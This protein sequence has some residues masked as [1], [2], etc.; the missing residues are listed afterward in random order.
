MYQ[1]MLLKSINVD[2]FKGDVGPYFRIE[3][4]NILYGV[5]EPND[6]CRYKII[7]N[8]VEIFDIVE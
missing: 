1:L 6:L 4:R 8:F 3:L 7:I 5:N 2:I